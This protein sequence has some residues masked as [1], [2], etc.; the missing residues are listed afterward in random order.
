MPIKINDLISYAGA[1][2]PKPGKNG[3]PGLPSTPPFAQQEG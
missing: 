2:T 3:R 1:M